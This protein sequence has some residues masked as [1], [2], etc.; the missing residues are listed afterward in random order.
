[1]TDVTDLSNVQ[2]YNSNGLLS[3]S[4]VDFFSGNEGCDRVTLDV[5]YIFLYKD[6]GTGNFDF[7][8]QAESDYAWKFLNRFENVIKN[9]WGGG[10]PDG[11]SYS[12]L[13]I[14]ATLH[15]VNKTDG[16]NLDLCDQITT[17]S[18]CGPDNG[19]CNDVDYTTTINNII[20]SI[21]GENSINVYFNNEGAVWDTHYSNGN[22]L[23]TCNRPIQNVGPNTGRFPNPYDLTQFNKVQM[24]NIYLGYLWRR[25]QP[26]CIL[27]DNG[28]SYDPNDIL[29][30]YE[31]SVGRTIGHEVGHT[32]SLTHTIYLD[33]L[34]KGQ[35]FNI[36]SSVLNKV[37]S[38][39]IK[40]H[41]YSGYG[42]ALY[43]LLTSEIISS[44]LPHL[45]GRNSRLRNSEENKISIDISPNPF[46]DRLTIES[47]GLTDAN[48][49]ITNS[50][51]RV[52]EKKI[53]EQTIQF[54][55]SSWSPGLYVV[56]IENDSNIITQEKLI[57][58][59]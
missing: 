56:T 6:D 18:P 1:M 34:I 48:L 33:K 36:S 41:P 12:G 51:G 30:W 21:D 42:K 4:G 46:S 50:M 52:I 43:Y 26:E 40:R 49:T 59:K 58:L 35:N 32:L 16:W 8:N 28:I 9:T 27:D 15:Q 53:L 10:C 22:Y 14:N 24:V 19:L 57:F 13:E 23:T 17:G 2:G 5:N 25:D 38:I 37:R 29:L 11:S 7:N 39:A 31:K 54:N 55:T 44:E 20:E 45:D 47:N 3:L